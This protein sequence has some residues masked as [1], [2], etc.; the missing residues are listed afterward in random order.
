MSTKLN[1]AIMGPGSISVAFLND[2]R[3]A[4]LQVSAVGSRSIDR[5]N[6]FAARHGIPNAYG[7]YEELV[8]DNQVDIVYIA[9]TNNAHFGNAKLALN[10]GK[11][12]LLEKPFT[13]D[14]TQATELVR[15]ARSKNVFLMEAMWTRFLP[16]HTVLFEKLADGI[17]GE[18]LY[19]MADH[20]Q[21]LPKGSFPRLHDPALGGGSLLDLGVYPISLA[22][23][24]FGNPA[25]IQASASLM[26]G[27][28]DESVA[29]IFDYSG[30]R[31]A[32]LHSSLR[33][34]GPVKA[35][36]LGTSGRIEMDKSFYGFS[37][38]TAFDFDDNVIFQYEGNIEGRGM[39][40]QALEVERCIASG[41]IESPIMSLD[42]TIQ[43]MEVMD[44]I[45]S[46]TG[47]EYQGAYPVAE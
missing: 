27:N 43:I 4:G 36:I 28:V 6:A 26:A 24:L 5:A 38:F 2:I 45:R 17:I 25:R 33:S 22:H 34:T 19:L 11:H 8:A 20:N 30:G 7:S 46:L 9:S 12:V 37:P 29:S 23:R 32:V 21:N 47:I 31:Q 10:A 1:W 35:F 13:L 41:L 39:Q 44:E 42:E 3:L 14:A 18:P 16:N 15:I 40:Y